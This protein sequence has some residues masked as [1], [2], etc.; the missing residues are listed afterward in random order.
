MGAGRGLSRDRQKDR[1]KHS[2]RCSQGMCVEALIIGAQAA[3]RDSKQNELG[4][5]QPIIELSTARFLVFQDELLGLAPLGSNGEIAV[6]ELDDGWVAFRSLSTGVELRYDA[7]ELSA[8]IDGVRAG[9]FR[10]AL[11]SA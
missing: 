4:A 6:D 10:P 2:T 3:L 9:E 8:F 1:W 5:L 7:D 11:A